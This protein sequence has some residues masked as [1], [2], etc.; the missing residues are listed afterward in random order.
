ML[1]LD[2]DADC[3]SG[4]EHLGLALGGNESSL[5]PRLNRGDRSAQS[6]GRL[7]GA[8]EP[9]DDEGSGGH[10]RIYR[11]NGRPVNDF[12]AHT[13]VRQCRTLRP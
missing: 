7:S 6:S 11:P 13:C 12:I 5:F 3:P 10:V 4:A 8:T 1:R 2:L 9:V